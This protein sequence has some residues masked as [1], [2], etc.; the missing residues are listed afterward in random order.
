MDIGL[1][2]EMAKMGLL[3]K[4]APKKYF[5]QGQP[6]S[7]KKRAKRKQARQSRKRNRGK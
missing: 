4:P 3:D 1:M 5:K 2:A 7:A 6:G